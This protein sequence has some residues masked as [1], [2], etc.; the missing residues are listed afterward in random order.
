[1]Q[2]GIP[3]GQPLLQVPLQDLVF[4]QKKVAGTIVGGRADMQVRRGVGGV[5]SVCVCVVSGRR[6]GRRVLAAAR[7]DGGRGG[8]GLVNE[9]L[10]CSACHKHAWHMRYLA[11][12]TR[13]LHAAPHA[14]RSPRPHH[15]LPH[16]PHHSQT[17]DVGV[18][19]HQRRQAHAGD[20]AAVQGACECVCC[21]CGVCVAC[22]CSG[23]EGEGIAGCNLAD[24][25]VKQRLRLRAAAHSC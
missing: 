25:P 18:L 16:Q 21:V 20:N 15:T 19:R 2:V 13:T 17:G 3:G 10:T 11:N 7:G 12:P 14:T 24:K 22:V 23:W 8:V 9:G 6:R 5:L 4:G 1:M